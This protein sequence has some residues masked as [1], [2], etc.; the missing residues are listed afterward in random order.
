MGDDLPAAQLTEIGYWPTSIDADR[1]HPEAFRDPDWSDQERQLVL[2]HLSAGAPLPWE[3]G[4]VEWCFFCGGVLVVDELTDG[5]YVWPTHLIHYVSEHDVRV[6]GL[7]VLHVQ[8][9]RRPS[10][11]AWGEEFV[12]TGPRDSDWWNSLSGP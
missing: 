11:P 1:P 2:Q 7:F 12:E 4:P 6:P 3:G 9:A 8:R 10:V 5:T